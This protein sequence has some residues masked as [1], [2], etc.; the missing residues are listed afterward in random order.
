MTRSEILDF[1]E[2]YKKNN[3]EKYYIEQLGIFGSYA[4]DEA[5]SESDIDV[6]VKMT[7]PDMYALI[8]IKQDIEE[9]F[10]SKVDIV[11]IRERMNA[12][13]KSRIYKDAIYV[14]QR[15]SSW[16]IEK[17]DFVSKKSYR[18]IECKMFY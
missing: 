18:S 3:S 17:H 5:T 14:W 8:G 16:S 1:L 10:K 6:V 4:R 15:V 11:Q 13:L 12:L 7:K 2:E 9:Y